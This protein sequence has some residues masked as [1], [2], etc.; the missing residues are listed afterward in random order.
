MR[1][2][3]PW[4][5]GRG[6]I[7]ARRGPGDGDERREEF[8]MRFAWHWMEST[9]ACKD[10]AAVGHVSRHRANAVSADAVR[11]KERK[12]KHAKRDRDHRHLT[13]CRAPRLSGGGGG[14][15][16]TRGSTAVSA[17]SR[18]TAMTMFQSCES[19]TPC[20]TVMLAGACEES[21]GLLRGRG[22]GGGVGVSTQ[23]VVGLCSDWANSYQPLLPPL[24]CSSPR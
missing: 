13:S 20:S 3:W 4:Q 15:A 9:C 19:V 24:P 2:R 23:R 17:S 10:A 22:R 14:P 16:N 7:A 12:R 6:G 11:T 18:S 8:L 1:A 21:P 5:S